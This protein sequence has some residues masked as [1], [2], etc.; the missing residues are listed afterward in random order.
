[1]LRQ[2][3]RPLDQ[4]LQPACVAKQVMLLS[5]RSA[6]AKDYMTEAADMQE[7]C[8]DLGSG[9]VTTQSRLKQA[10]KAAVCCFLL[11]QRERV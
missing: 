4:Y 1:M 2:H 11:S 6:S 5:L 8:L 7:C 10:T 3:V 9:N